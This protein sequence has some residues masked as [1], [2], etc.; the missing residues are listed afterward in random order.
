MNSRL[1]RYLCFAATFAV[2]LLALV[3]VHVD[4]KRTRGRGDGESIA[5]IVADAHEHAKDHVSDPDDLATAEKVRINESRS[6]ARTRYLVEGH[7]GG[8]SNESPESFAAG[9]N[10]RKIL[11]TPSVPIDSGD[12]IREFTDVCATPLRKCSRTLPLAIRVAEASNVGDGWA[13]RMEE[14]I[15]ASVRS[16]AA[17]EAIEYYS[18]LCSA[19]GCLL[20]VSGRNGEIFL[21]LT[22]DGVKPLRAYRFL[23]SMRDEPWTQ[24]MAWPEQPRNGRG[25]YPGDLW[26]QISGDH[27]QVL[28]VFERQ[29]S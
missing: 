19:E 17:K 26:Q 18:V 2:L 14:E 10:D 24:E 15:A 9:A 4:G 8:R 21:D 20:F 16:V 22:E 27:L 1:T 11:A 25:G 12:W 5:V 3:F 13:F 6:T 7:E 29:K 28:Y 23:G